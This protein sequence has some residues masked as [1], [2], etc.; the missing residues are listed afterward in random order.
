MASH[1]HTHILGRS[2]LFTVCILCI[3]IRGH[4]FY[5]FEVIS[6]WS[7]KVPCFNRIEH[8]LSKDAYNVACYTLATFFKRPS[9]IV[10]VNDVIISIHH[11]TATL[12]ERRSARSD[13]SGPNSARQRTSAR[14]RCGERAICR[15]ACRVWVDGASLQHAL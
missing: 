11:H 5:L 4:I 12:P 9:P 8:D 14:V 10:I 6:I 1:T 2:P 3:P 13:H 7:T 15:A